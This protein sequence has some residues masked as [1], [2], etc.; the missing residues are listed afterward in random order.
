MWRESHIGQDPAKA[1]KFR[2]GSSKI[3][4]K[5]LFVYKLFY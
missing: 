3:E 4:N 1:L 5:I 2:G